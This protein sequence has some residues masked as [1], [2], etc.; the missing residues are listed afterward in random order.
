[1]IGMTV[2]TNKTLLTILCN[3]EPKNILGDPQGSCV[4]V[5]A[6]PL[7]SPF[8]SAILHNFFPTFFWVLLHCY[9]IPPPNLE[10]SSES[11]HR[12]GLYFTLLCFPIV[13]I[14]LP[15]NIIL[16]MKV[17]RKYFFVIRLTF[18]DVQM[19]FFLG[20]NAIFAWHIHFIISLL[21]LLSTVSWNN[22]FLE[23]AYNII[24]F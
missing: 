19:S 10:H 14:S 9:L 13:Q 8:L 4:V 12:R 24:V 20:L 5:M 16:Q 21:L 3:Y 17:L 1:M 11:S 2:I 22:T 18:F 15:C 23:I 7:I 6:N